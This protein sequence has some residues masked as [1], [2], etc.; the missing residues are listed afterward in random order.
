MVS[1][2]GRITGP[3]R[4]APSKRSSSDCAP[5]CQSTRNP[6]ASEA[7]SICRS[8]IPNPKTPLATQGSPYIRLI[9]R[10]VGALHQAASRIRAEDSTSSGIMQPGTN[11]W[12]F[13]SEAYGSPTKL[14][15]DSR[16]SDR[17]N[18]NFHYGPGDDA[19]CVLAIRGLGI[20]VNELAM[21]RF[22]TDL[23]EC[24]DKHSRLSDQSLSFLAADLVKALT[25]RA[26][27]AHLLPPEI[28]W[29]ADLTVSIWRLDEEEF[30][31][32]CKSIDLSH[33]KP[34]GIEGSPLNS[35]DGFKGNLEQFRELIELIDW[36]N[37]DAASTQRVSGAS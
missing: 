1:V 15:R 12:D 19:Y 24:A 27:T 25:S 20:D 10:A 30:W 4:I 13:A 8:P 28:S 34:L 37:P 26:E 3:V 6:D 22:L 16:M 32:S 31:F 33:L 2:D 36:R 5:F 7:G 9:S 21:Q 35:L 18:V 11:A 14:F 17:L 29:P 23:V